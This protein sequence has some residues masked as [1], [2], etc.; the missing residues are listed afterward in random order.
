ME[1]VGG[2]RL[3][4]DVALGAGAHPC[5]VAPRV[6]ALG[7]DRPRRRRDLRALGHR[8]GLQDPAAVPRQ[9]LVLV[10]RAGA[11]PRH[12]QLP[13]TARSQAAQRVALTVPRV[14][15]SDD[16]D[17]ARVGRPD[18]EGHAGDAVV[19]ADVGAERLPELFVSAFRD[20]VAIDVAEGG[21]VAI[22]VVGAEVRR[23]VVRGDDL[24]GARLLRGG[25]FPDAGAHMV[26][27]DADALVGD[28]R[29]RRRH[30]APG[31]DHPGA[32]GAAVRA[33]DVVRC[34]VGAGGD[35]VEHLV[36]YVAHRDSFTCRMWTGSSN[37]SSRTK[38]SRFHV[39]VAPVTRSST[40]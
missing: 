35:G 13:D 3:R 40:T 19:V 1:L 6:R 12:E 22:G 16:A 30:R 38:L 33:Q 23:T 39:Q 18:G 25:A 8:V 20:E 27:G 11:E 36:G 15:V 24:V 5:A 14:E 17:R 7:D 37:A 26:Q 29:D 9:D 21:E 2:H 4:E 34:V 10:H 28:R 32:V 31:A